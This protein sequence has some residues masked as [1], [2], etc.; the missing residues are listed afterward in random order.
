MR[1]AL[2]HKTDYVAEYRVV[3]PDGSERW[4]A[5]RGRLYSENDGKADRIG[6]VAID[7]TERKLAEA[8]VRELHN[9]LARASRISI[10]GQLAT[11][12]AHELN[13]PLGAILLNAEAAGLLLNKDPLPSGELRAILSDIC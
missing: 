11:S 13:Q 10:M 7:I 12:I 9:Q 2:E 6:G 4:L 3:L 1:Q 8:Q 5:S